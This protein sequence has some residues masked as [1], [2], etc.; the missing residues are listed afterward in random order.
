M[1]RYL[2]VLAVMMFPVLVL[3]QA[4][5]TK[6]VRITTPYSTGIGPDLFARALADTLQKEWGQP[7][8][9]ESRPG[10]NGFIAIDVLKKS[11]PDGHELLILADSHLAINPSLFKKLPY[12]VDTDMVPVG[13]LYRTLFFVVVKS[14]GPYQTIAQLIAG[15]KAN[16]GK[17][18]YG[19]PYVGSPSHLGN[20]VFD[21]E[22]GTQTIHVPYKEQLQIFTSIANGDLTWAIATAAST[23]AM[24]KAGRVKLIAVAANKRLASH[25]EVP[26]V[27]EAGGPKDFV[28]AAWLALLAPQGTPQNIVRKIS[29]DTQ[30]ALANPD[31]KKRI[32]ALG[33]EGMPSSPEQIAEMIRTATRKNAEIIKRVGATAD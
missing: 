4:F 13:G 22:T 31:M 19:T 24:V 2:T 27:E 30:K 7:V 6:T 18:T 21:Y 8:V 29:A 10:A 3:A 33:F 17:L 15:A 14:D 32:D 5:P 9:V 1:T 20:A 28:V 12:N 11:A 26:T 16:P 23:T 25:P